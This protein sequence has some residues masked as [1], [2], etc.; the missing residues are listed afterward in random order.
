[1]P[2]NWRGCRQKQ[3]VVH[4]DNSRFFNFKRE[5][6]GFLTWITADTHELLFIGG[7]AGEGRWVEINRTRI[8]QRSRL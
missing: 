4:A 6:A 5:S 2:S 1:L 3:S 8:S 7:G